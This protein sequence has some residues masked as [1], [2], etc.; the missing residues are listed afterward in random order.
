[1]KGVIKTHT[2]RIYVLQLQYIMEPR[3][4]SFKLNCQGTFE[5]D[6]DQCLE[7]VAE[8]QANGVDLNALRLQY[9]QGILLDEQEHR[10]PWMPHD[11]LEEDEME[12]DS[13]EERRLEKNYSVLR[14]EYITDLATYQKFHD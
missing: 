3:S 10:D 14:S 12:I 4:K 7:A 5:C 2:S 6:C 13:D 8:A 9:E 11:P 1:V